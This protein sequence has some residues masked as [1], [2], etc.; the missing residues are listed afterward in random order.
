M[1]WV[2][3]FERVSGV[4]VGRTLL[5]S[6]LFV[7]LGAGVLCGEPLRVM[8]FNIRF[9]TAA[10]GDDAWPLRRALLTKVIRD[11]RPDLLAVQEALDFQLQELIESL[12]GYRRLGVGRDDGKSLGEFS[13]ILYRA[14]R[15]RLSESGTFWFSDTP[16]AP[17]SKSWGNQI[18]RICSWGAFEDQQ[19]AAASGVKRLRAFNVHWDHQSQPS[20][21]KSGAMLAQRLAAAAPAGEA[22]VV[23]GDFNAGEDNPAFRA[24]L[25]GPIGV[26]DSFR[27]LHADATDVGTFHAFAG[28][29]TGAKIDAV[30]VSRHWKV[31]AAEIVRTSQEKRYPSDHFP[32]TAIIEGAK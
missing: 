15:L 32:V 3:E 11:F 10:D 8:T 19:A 17:G 9:G 29:V 1:V 14:E 27:R 25:R 6:A 5:F 28:T 12:A 21:E 26:F 7:G 2:D 31:L 30:L 23:T 16:D 18:S 22:I 4:I 24:L 20:R 13:A